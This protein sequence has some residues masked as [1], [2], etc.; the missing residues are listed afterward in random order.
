MHSAPAVSY[1]VGRSRFHAGLLLVITLMGA[2][3]VLTWALKVDA[4][5]LRHLAAGLLCV[6]CAGLATLHWWRTP[7][8]QLCWDGTAWAWEAADRVQTVVPEVTL[9]LQFCLLLRLHGGVG[10]SVQWVWP[11]RRTSTPHWQ[12]FR[13]AVYGKTPSAADHQRNTGQAQQALAR[14]GS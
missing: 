4:P 2:L 1:P 7:L 3:T 6:T 11:E 12:A 13:R 14:A 5:G 10:P 9:D 8:A